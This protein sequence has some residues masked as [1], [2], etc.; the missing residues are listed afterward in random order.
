ME[1]DDFF[2]VE[3][4]KPLH[5]LRSIR[6]K[7]VSDSVEAI[8]AAFYVTG[9][10]RSV[11]AVIKGLGFWPTIAI[12]EEKSVSAAENVEHNNLLVNSNETVFIPEGY[13]SLLERMALGYTS[14]DVT[15]QMKTEETFSKNGTTSTI[16][17]TTEEHWLKQSESFRLVECS[18]ESLIEIISD[19]IGYTFKD[20]QLLDEAL[21]HSSVLF[22]QSNQRLEFLGD[23]LIDFIVVEAV[24]SVDD[25][26]KEW[27][28]GKLTMRKIDLANN[29]TLSRIACKLRIY[30][31]IN[32]TST[33]LLRDYEKIDAWFETQL[34]NQKSDYETLLREV[35]SEQTDSVGFN[36][37]SD[38]V[39]TA[40]INNMKSGIMKTLADCLEAIVGAV[41]IDSE[42]NLET[43]KHC[44]SHIKVI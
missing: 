34:A 30:R 37:I 18:K 20:F 31:Y 25:R 15:H 29:K 23:S 11:I 1:A 36:E 32:M 4:V 13:P 19:L 38:N 27:S 14:F 43:I 40:Y 17:I 2:K 10:L 44:L 35:G 6:S 12:D 28:Q 21:T 22:K 39:L 7:L 24:F 26:S 41:Y 5:C 8:V 16:S 33:Q 42:G 3:Y 9:G